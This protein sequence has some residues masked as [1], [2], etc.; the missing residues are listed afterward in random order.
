M[1]NPENNEFAVSKGKI[2]LI[3]ILM[4][5]GISLGS[6]LV[7]KQSKPGISQRPIKPAPAAPATNQMAWIPGG[8]FWMGTEQGHSDESPMHQVTVSGFWMDRTE[9]T[10]EEFAKFVAATGYETVAERKPDPRDFPEAPPEALVPG[11]AVFTPPTERVPLEEFYRW[12]RYLPGANW[13]QP[14][15]PGSSIAGKEKH[16]VVHISWEDASAYANWAGK[17]L[18]TE[19]EWEF[20]ARGGLERQPFVW[21]ETQVPD[22]KWA[23]N[24]W[25]GD[26]PLKNEVTDGFASTAPVGSFAPNGYGLYD[27]AGN[28]WEWC[29][30][31]YR[32]DYYASSPKANPQ[33]PPDSFDP[34]EPNMPK[35]VQR[36][37]SF[38]CSDV[39]CSGYRPSARMKA[40]PDTGLSHSGFRCVKDAPAPK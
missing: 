25:Q 31:W 1:S 20:A 2:V 37:G 15:G 33:G 17:R 32:P 40:S 27:M 18:P 11:S 3:L 39:Y 7:V 14:E 29:W 38:L 34:N 5:G 8:T 36:G 4:V 28:V 6:F 23:A 26:F 19:A 16:P 21:G 9:V 24:I 12:W 22:G 30:D 10:N 13:R 35:R